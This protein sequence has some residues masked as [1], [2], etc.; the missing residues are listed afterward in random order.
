MR[1]GLL[2]KLAKNGEDVEYGEHLVRETLDTVWRIVEDEADE[3][4]DKNTERRLGVDIGWCAPILLEDTV[5]NLEE[6]LVERRRELAVTAIISRNGGLLLWLSLET[7]Q[8]L[9]D[10]SILGAITPGLEPIN[11]GMGTRRG[12]DDFKHPFGRV[13]I[14]W[15]IESAV[16]LEI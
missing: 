14:R 16:P 2:Y 12:A 8:L 4:S 6:L 3:E 5:G 11:I 13:S 7:L 9:L 10:S 15:A 1:H